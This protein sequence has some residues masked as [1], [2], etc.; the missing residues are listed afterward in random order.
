MTAAASCL[1]QDSSFAG[2]KQISNTFVGKIFDEII[3]GAFELL[4]SNI[5]S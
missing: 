2:K 3:C 4:P 5:R 1:K